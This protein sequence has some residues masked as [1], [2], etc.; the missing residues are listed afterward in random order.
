MRDP[1]RRGALN[2]LTILGACC[3][4]GLALAAIKGDGAGWRFVVGNLSAPY[5]IP[6]LLAGRAAPTTAAAV[7]RGVAA[8]TATLLGFYLW[9]AAAFALVTRDS[10]PH[11][12]LITALGTALGASFGA[13]GSRTR[14]A[15]R[16]IVAL[17]I[18]T[19]FLLEP[20]VQV[21]PGRLGN[22]R[23]DPAALQHYPYIFLAEVI[24]GTIGA[25]L[26]L[27]TKDRGA[28]SKSA[29]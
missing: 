1:S 4:F 7:G 16:G 11:V 27:S 20:V 28:A 23:G 5:V 13:L 6:P 19:P 10:A 29:A 25:L 26:F 21:L 22:L 3:A 9:E 12:L 24:L 2:M 8:V 17:S 18:A 15:M 14:R